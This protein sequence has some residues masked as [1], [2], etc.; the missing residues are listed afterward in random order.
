MTG[1]TC[2]SKFLSSIEIILRNTVVIGAYHFIWCQQAAAIRSLWI[3]CDSSEWCVSAAAHSFAFLCFIL[4][5][6]FKS[7]AAGRHGS[8]RGHLSWLLISHWWKK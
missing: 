7:V 3:L 5:S 4:S 8:S 2:S 1:D 6:E